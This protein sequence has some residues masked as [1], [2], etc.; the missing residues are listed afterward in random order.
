MNFSSNRMLVSSEELQLYDKA[1]I[2]ID[3][4]FSCAE[5]FT[6]RILAE[7]SYWF[8]YRI[9]VTRPFTLSVLGLGKFLF[10]TSNCNGYFDMEFRRYKMAFVRH[11]KRVFIFIR[12]YSY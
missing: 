6:V 1:E 9:D 2:F 3:E 10:R 7:R 8:L 5:N 4:D 12:K 11:S